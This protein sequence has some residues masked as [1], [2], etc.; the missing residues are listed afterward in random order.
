MSAVRAPASVD[1]GAVAQADD[2][3]AHH[4]ETI[5]ACGMPSVGPLPDSEIPGAALIGCNRLHAMRLRARWV[6]T[7]VTKDKAL[8]GATPP[9]RS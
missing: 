2:E 4:A 8:A 5:I 1:T 6:E 9:A 3:R 7:H